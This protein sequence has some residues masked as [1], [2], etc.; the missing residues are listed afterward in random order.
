V[1]YL[2]YEG[3]SQ[4]VTELVEFI[5]IQPFTKVNHL[6]DAGFFAEKTARKYLNQLCDM[7]VMELKSNEGKH[8]KKLTLFLLKKHQKIEKRINSQTNKTYFS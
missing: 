3:K 8:F 1:N 2:P 5:F 6:T 7:Q 4:Q